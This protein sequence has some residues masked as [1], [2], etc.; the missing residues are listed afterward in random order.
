MLGFSVIWCLL[1]NSSFSPYFASMVLWGYC[2]YWEVVFCCCEDW[3][4]QWKVLWG[5]VFVMMQLLLL[6]LQWA[7]HSCNINKN[8][9]KTFAIVN[10]LSQ[11]NHTTY[12]NSLQFG[13]FCFYATYYNLLLLLLQHNCYNDLDLGTLVTWLDKGGEKVRRGADALGQGNC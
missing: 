4:G 8:V 12:F 7:F 1:P 3:W 10:L 6:S 11:F 9:A 2:S 5:K 13:I